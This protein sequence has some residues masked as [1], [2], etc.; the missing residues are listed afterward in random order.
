MTGWRIVEAERRERSEIQRL[1]TELF[2]AESPRRGS[3]LLDTNPAGRGICL[4]ALDSRDRVM[5][6]RSLLRWNLLVDGTRV[7]V[8]QYARSWTHPDFRRQG[9]SVAIGEEL[10]RRSA[11]LGHPLLFLFPSDRSAPGHR[12]I[13]NV[14]DTLLERR[15]ALLS[16]RFLSPRLPG[17]LDGILR[18]VQSV[19][20]RGTGR[21]LRRWACLR[22]P[23]READR[24]WEAGAPPS[25]VRGV[26]DGAFVAWRYGPGSGRPYQVW[27]YPAGDTIRILAATWMEGR[28]GRVLDLWGDIDDEEFAGAVTSLVEEL[29]RAG[30]WLVEWCPPRLGRG[31]NAARDAGLVRRRRGVRF[32]R[33]FHRPPAELGPLAELGRYRLTEGDSDYA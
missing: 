15:Q 2:G 6:T 16:V 31:P 18:G 1:E 17:V 3:W 24:L 9:V 19:R 13:G 25:G 7:E 20:R 11:A 5:G 22:D 26:R 4:V 23:R 8:G 33:W 21:R 14:L 32:A 27:G 29:G 10:N 28:R 30:A 12:R